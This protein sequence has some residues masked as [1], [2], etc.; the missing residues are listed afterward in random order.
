MNFF[1]KKCR[2]GNY[3]FINGM[4]NWIKDL[5]KSVALNDDNVEK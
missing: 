4:D 5:E 2:E 3:V 1:K